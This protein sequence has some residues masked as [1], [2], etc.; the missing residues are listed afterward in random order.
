MDTTALP[1]TAE[2]L[3]ELAIGLAMLVYAVPWVAGYSL[4]CRLTEYTHAA[5]LQAHTYVIVK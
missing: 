2:E 5:H 1:E 3:T 4:P